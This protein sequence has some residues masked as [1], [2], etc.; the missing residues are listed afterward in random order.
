M[1]GRPIS[2][3]GSEERQAK[4]S[5]STLAK[6]TGVERAKN[7]THS[8]VKRKQLAQPACRRTDQPKSQEFLCPTASVPGR[9]CW[10]ENERE[11]LVSEGWLV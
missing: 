3:V 11:E 9:G 5:L 10:D 4:P 2:S 1:E 7:T 6:V 8:S